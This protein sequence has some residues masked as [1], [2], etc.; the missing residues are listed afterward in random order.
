MKLFT[1][2]LMGILG[3]AGPLAAGALLTVE[4]ESGRGGVSRK[5]EIRVEGSWVRVDTPSDEYKQ[6]TLYNDKTGALV[7]VDGQRKVFRQVDLEQTAARQED[8]EARQAQ[9]MQ[10]MEKRI[11][12]LPPE[13]QMVFRSRLNSRMAARDAA[14]MECQ[15][16]AEGEAVGGWTADRYECSVGSRQVREVWVLPWQESGLDAEEVAALQAFVERRA[17]SV[18]GPLGVRSG[19]LSL[20]ADAH[21]GLAVRVRHIRDGAAQQGH[22]ISSIK[23]EDFDASLFTVDAT[24]SEAEAGNFPLAIR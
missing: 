1:K 5:H 17:G 24:Y 18:G 6:S 19:G 8:S 4:V 16:V 7:L 13:K 14:Q 11:R 21:P 20:S 10:A 3:I 9:F 23:R 22:E 2:L 15:R 12:T